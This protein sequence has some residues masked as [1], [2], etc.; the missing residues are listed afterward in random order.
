MP[1][2]DTH[3]SLDP[4]VALRRTVVA[5]CVFASFIV[6][7]GPASAGPLCS[8]M[9]F[10]GVND[11]NPFDTGAG[12]GDGGDGVICRNFFPGGGDNAK[13][14]FFDTAFGGFEHL[15]RVTVEEVLEPFG[16]AFFRNYLPAG[17]TFGPNFPNHVCVAYAQNGQCVEYSAVSNVNGLQPI[18]STEFQPV[19]NS[20][21]VGPITWLIAWSNPL[22]GTNPVPE[23]IH[24]IGEN[25]DTDEIYDEILQGIFFSASLSPFDFDCDNPYY[26][27]CPSESEF[28]SIKLPGDAVRASLSDNFTDVALVQVVPEPG[29]MTLL[30]LGAGGLLLKRRRRRAGQ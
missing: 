11:D 15:L 6:C 19:R 21:Y 3:M 24:E 12:G 22:V 14:Y 23:I 1:V 4:I 28:L 25:G 30:A 2:G 18:D 10:A 7:A 29:T 8:E 9:G 13:F 26:D 17:T 5:V 16:L 20:E 27:T